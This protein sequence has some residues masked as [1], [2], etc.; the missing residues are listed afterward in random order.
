MPFKLTAADRRKLEGVQADL[1]KVIECAAQIS[2][3]KFRLTEGLRTRARQEK[4]VRSGASKTMNSRHLTGHA[5]DLVPLV[6]LNGNGK[7]DLNEIYAWPLYHKLAPYIKRA[8]Q[9]VGVVV[10]WG[11]DWRTFKDGPHWQLPWKSYPRYSAYMQDEA[12]ITEET[13]H[14]HR[15]KSTAAAGVLGG[16]ASGT[17]LADTGPRVVDAL[18]NQQGEITSG[19]M[20]RVAVAVAIL[21][22]TIYAIWR[23]RK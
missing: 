19:D 3:I 2:P 12:P 17:V 16:S 21:A 11:G 7:Y 8:A 6:D 14:E 1:V 9:E 23:A 10:E 13:E 4:L 18:S 20:I 5:V 15:T 22:I